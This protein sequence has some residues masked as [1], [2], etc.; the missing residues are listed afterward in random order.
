MSQEGVGQHHSWGEATAE[1]PWWHGE[2][3]R[4]GIPQVEGVEGY[5]ESRSLDFNVCGPEL[6]NSVASAGQ[7]G[8]SVN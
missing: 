2:P 5:V 1:Q 3:M 6:A 8:I 4:D 7:V